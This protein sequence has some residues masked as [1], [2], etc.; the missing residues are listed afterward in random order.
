VRGDVDVV[1]LQYHIV[2]VQLHIWLLQPSDPRFL[3]VCIPYILAF[4]D[5]HID[6][7]MNRIAARRFI[8]AGLFRR[9]FSQSV[10][11]LSESSAGRTSPRSWSGGAVVGVAAAAGIV[12]W[13]AAKVGSRKN[14]KPIEAQ[15]ASGAKPVENRYATLSEMEQVC[16]LASRV[17]DKRRILILDG[18]YTG[19]HPRVGR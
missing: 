19:D 10:T 9:R 14:E 13:G 11:R 4:F 6:P 18:G 16:T 8:G 2:G 17:L 1:G 12:G 7:V 5:T 15:I 3:D